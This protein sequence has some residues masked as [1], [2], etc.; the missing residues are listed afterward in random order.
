MRSMIM[1][2]VMSPVA[3]GTAI[4]EVNFWRS[5]NGLPSLIEDQVLTSKAQA[6]AEYRAA[7]LLKDG[8]DGPRCPQGC[9][10]GTGEASPGWG[11]LTCVMEETGE[12]AGAG[13]A[14]GADGQR[15]MVLLLRGS[16]ESA[17]IGRQVR[18]ARTAQLTPNAPVIR[19]IP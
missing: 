13:V 2:L 10:E 12:S 7:R 5:K 1:V 9:R 18:P 6:K 3:S 14:I 15:Y 17:P 11:W 8:H 19:K 4:E 16:R